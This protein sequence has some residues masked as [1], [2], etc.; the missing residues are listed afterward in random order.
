MATEL[1]LTGTA[2]LFFLSA[3]TGN[4]SFLDFLYAHSLVRLR[5]CLE[6]ARAA[7]HEVTLVL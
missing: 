2:R 5:I 3:H 4:L 6:T 1:L 7:F